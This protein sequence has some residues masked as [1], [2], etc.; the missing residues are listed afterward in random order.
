M[1]LDAVIIVLRETLEAGIL[2]SVLLTISNQLKLGF[3]WLWFALTGSLIGSIVY[4]GNLGIVSEWF[5]YAGQEVVNA[6]IQYGIY[7][8]LLA[9]CLLITS[10][11]PTGRRTLTGLLSLAVILASIREG[12][13]IIL[14]FMGFLHDSNIFSKAL[15]SGFIGLMIGF[16]VGALCYYAIVSSGHRW[17]RPIQIVVLT[18]MAA[19]MVAQATR[20]LIQADWLPS[21]A[22]IWDTRGLLPEPSLLG[23][24]AYATFGYE[25]TPTPIEAW[26]YIGALA[27]IPLSILLI[28]RI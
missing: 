26:L 22:P 20:L 6:T 25:A 19:G 16:S 10:P 23:Q 24:L 18:M 11:N 5:D 15:T 17:S 4:V 7:L 9:I 14:F 8:C 2:I 28:R 27:L 1:L 12:T 13:E 21:R 3:G